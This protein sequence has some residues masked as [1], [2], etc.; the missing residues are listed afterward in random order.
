MLNF[1]KDR[2]VK[3]Q[4]GAVSIAGEVRALVRKL[5][6]EGV[7]RLFFM[8]TGGVQLLTLPGDR[9]GAA[10]LDLPGQRASIRRRS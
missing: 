1:D 5:L 2:F 8:G 4:T 7:E 10:P 6:A 3:I 9:A